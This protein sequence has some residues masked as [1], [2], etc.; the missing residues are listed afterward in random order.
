MDES[1]REA[2]WEAYFEADFR[3]RYFL[4]VKARL[5]RQMKWL[6]VAIGVLSCGPLANFLFA[7]GYGDL[8]SG[9]T[10]LAAGAVGVYVAASGIA[11]T[12][13]VATQAATTWGQVRTKRELLWRRASAGEDVWTQHEVSQHETEWIDAVVT[14]HLETDDGRL[15]KAWESAKAAHVATA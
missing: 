14:E 4:S 2:V 1:K 9:G 7:F 12:I 8:V 13:A 11:R 6:S 10:G 3:H 5:Q 15:S